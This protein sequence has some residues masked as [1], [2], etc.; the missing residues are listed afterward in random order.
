[1]CA[2]AALEARPMYLF[3]LGENLTVAVHEIAGESL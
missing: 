1:M 3:Y 2:A